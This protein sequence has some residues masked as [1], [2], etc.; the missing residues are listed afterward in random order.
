G[1]E[2]AAVL[3]R[4]YLSDWMERCAA[5]LPGTRPLAWNAYAIATRIGWWVR[6]FCFLGRPRFEAWGRFGKEFLP[7]LWQ[8]AAYLRNHLE[9]DLR[10]NHLL[11]DAVGLA[12]AGRF[13]AGKRAGEWLA[14][15]TDLAVRQ[16]RE[17]VLPDGGHFERSPMYHLEVME[18]V[19]ALSFL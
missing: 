14:A 17:Q 10:G 3:F 6:S 2:D 12:W 11:R 8:Q 15:A 13:F 7:S 1:A 9:W 18:D 19:V 16:T 4:H 5:G